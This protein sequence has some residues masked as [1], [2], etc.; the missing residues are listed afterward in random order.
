[1]RRKCESKVKSQ[2]AAFS[3]A[4]SG[5]IIERESRLF[6]VFTKRARSVYPYIDVLNGLL[7]GRGWSVTQGL[8]RFDEA[9]LSG[10]CVVFNPSTLVQ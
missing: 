4:G 3:I 5:R 8:K 6:H 7:A 10:E 2:L 1:M 9:G